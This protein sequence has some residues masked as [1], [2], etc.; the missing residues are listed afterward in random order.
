M[1]FPFILFSETMDVKLVDVAFEQKLVG[2][3]LHFAK[4]C[5]G[6]LFEEWQPSTTQLLDLHFD[7]FRYASCWMIHH[8]L[9]QLWLVL[10][11]KLMEIHNN[12]LSRFPSL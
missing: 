10:E 12:L 9:R 2:P 3:L 8:F 7:I 6:F 11:G 4:R 5:F 1:V